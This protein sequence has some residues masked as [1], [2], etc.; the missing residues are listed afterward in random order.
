MFNTWLFF[1]LSRVRLIISIG[2]Y[3]LSLSF[4]ECVYKVHWFLCVRHTRGNNYFWTFSLP[5]RVDVY[6]SSVYVPGCGVR[7]PLQ[8]RMFVAVKASLEAGVELW[9]GVGANFIVREMCIF[10][11]WP[12]GRFSV[13]GEL[14][15]LFW[16]QPH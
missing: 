4:R 10:C 2:N 15:S 14:N 5:L 16:R 9:N 7:I 3:S 12:V 8:A 6:C 11:V 13:A 1:H